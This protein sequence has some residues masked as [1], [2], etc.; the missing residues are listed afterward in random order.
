MP[1]PTLFLAALPPD[2]A[3]RGNAVDTSESFIVQAP[4][5]SGKTMLLTERFLRLLATVDVPEQVLAITFTKAAVAEMHARAMHALSAAAAG[6]TPQREDERR[7]AEAASLALQ[8]AKLRG[9]NLLEDPQQLSIFTIDSLALQIAQSTPLLSR[10]G[11]GFSPTEDVQS[12]YQR[13]AMLTLRALGDL[14]SPDAAHRQVAQAAL[15]LLQHRENNFS[16]CAALIAAM[17]GNRDQWGRHFPLNAAELQEDYLDNHLRPALEHQLKLLTEEHLTITHRAFESSGIDTGALVDIAC[18][19]A[20][21][22][23]GEIANCA[24]LS[25]FPRPS[26]AEIDV[27]RGLSCLLLK[28]DGGLR[29]A[30]RASEGFPNGSPRKQAFRQ[31][32]ATIED[33]GP[34]HKSLQL[35]RNL[36]PIRLT[37]DEWQVT[38]ALFRLL[39]RA[40]VHLT[41]IFAESGIVDFTEVSLAART[42]LAAEESGAESAPSDL[43]FSLS[44]RYQHLLVDEFQD[45]SITQYEILVRLIAGW[46]VGDGR[47]VFLVGDPMQSIYLFR[48]A[49]MGLFTDAARH[50]LA[51]I[52]LQ[53][54]TLKVNFR[55]QPALI[56]EHNRVFSTVFADED[57]FAFVP[58]HAFG[59]VPAKPA[60]QWHF[61]RKPSSGAT[62]S[63]KYSQ[64]L[65]EA[66]RVHE[67]T[68]GALANPEHTVAIL[69]RAKNHAGLIMQQLRET[70]IPYRAIEME[71]LAE[72]QE[73]LDVLALT[74]ALLHPAD[75]SAWLSVFRAPWCGLSLASI[76]ILCHSDS[77]ERYARPSLADLLPRN[78]GKL[79]A[80]ER[81]RADHVAAILTEAWTHRDQLRLPQLVWRTWSQLGGKDCI[82]AEQYENVS[83]YFA[84]LEKMDAEGEQW[85][86]HSLSSRLD[87]LFA[88]PNP[89]P[90]ARVEV[91]TIHKAKGLGFDVVIVPHLDRTGANDSPAAIDW[92]DQPV[93]NEDAGDLRALFLAPV[94]AY[95]KDR[96]ALAK[97]ICDKKAARSLAELKRLFYVAATR[98]RYQLHLL[99]SVEVTNP[100]APRLAKPQAD[101][102][103]R[104]AWETIDP[105]LIWQQIA[106]PA[107]VETIAAGEVVAIRSDNST[108]SPRS[109]SI[110]RLPDDAFL[111]PPP[112][113]WLG[114]AATTTANLPSEAAPRRPSEIV[115]NLETR[116]R[117][118]VLHTL[119]EQAAR[120]LANGESFDQLSAW[121]ASADN[122]I[123]RLLGSEGLAPPKAKSN[124][125]QV[126]KLLQRTLGSPTGRWVLSPHSESLIE[127]PL[128]HWEDGAAYS[129]RM[130]RIFIA[131]DQPGQPGDTTVWIIDYKSVEYSGASEEEFLRSQVSLYAPVM[132]RYARAW[133]SLG[134]NSH[135][136][137]CA[138]YFPAQDKLEVL[139]S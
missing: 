17:L 99:A 80:D 98:A 43:A 1:E 137:R 92:F 70:R 61:F 60:L 111:A 62:P 13:A 46:E 95:G 39:Q 124:A 8:N 139:Q 132:Q 136:V 49:E 40:I 44:A 79:S 106:Q 56:E 55:S 27:W 41:T 76:E 91:L 7:L 10:L 57:Q 15:T 6:I 82:D 9:W 26:A 20:E 28:L 38:K 34:V 89:N 11:P 42:A 59:G 35:L 24:D 78:I 65:E 94:P 5:G 126:H 86:L 87:R 77:A 88:Q 127:F 81:K 83:A 47:S 74:R 85:N 25:H 121:A 58:S 52:P 68:E 100:T 53:H 114:I 4:A 110:R 109:T 67:L 133:Q 130:D 72:R 118:I 125:A 64:S 2:Q 93:A 63:E 54:I 103:L 122:L 135:P 128:T 107:V 134:R 113:D 50:G 123:R 105:A 19:A 3:A 66:I 29:K 30:P 116:A 131:E 73:V 23:T 22:A 138:L 119:L 69:V 97:W 12:Y 104:V 120:K 108:P 75:R 90:S 45:T 18:F 14:N 51:N 129:L 71:S 96:S 112:K 37:D 101:T 16:D 21:T 36:P 32:I 102:L 48:Q 84:L 117:G 31:F 33:D 115:A